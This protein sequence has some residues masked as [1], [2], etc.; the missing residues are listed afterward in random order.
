MLESL[1]IFSLQRIPPAIVH[2]CL[3]RALLEH[4]SY[5]DSQLRKRLVRNAYR[6]CPL[7]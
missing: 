2:R 4:R 1:S 7:L 5:N 6:L 3:N